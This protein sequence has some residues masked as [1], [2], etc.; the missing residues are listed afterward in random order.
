MSGCER[1]TDMISAFLD[2]ELNET[3]ERKLKAHLETCAECRELLEELS[4]VSG[5]IKTLEVDPPAGL[6]GGTMY[7][8]RADRAPGGRKH[9]RF[10]FGTFT[11]AA[12]VVAL[13]FLVGP[14]VLNNITGGRSGAD[15]AGSTALQGSFSYKS[16]EGAAVSDGGDSAVASENESTLT[17]ASDSLIAGNGTMENVPEPEATMG[18][19]YGIA[20]ADAEASAA[21]ALPYSNLFYGILVLTG[22]LPTELKEYDIIEISADERHIILPAEA[23]TEL[24]VRLDKDGVAYEYFDQEPN[25]SDQAEN[26]I[27]VLYSTDQAD[28][29]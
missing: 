25:T 3:E 21:P 4:A 7:K 1:Y 19:R 9:R 28:A 15:T 6:V 12:A 20:S 24:R 18:A 29:G 10:A 5:M 8:I 26:G 17:T 11:A 23:L 14:G 27:V 13:V 22:E 2:H 16:S